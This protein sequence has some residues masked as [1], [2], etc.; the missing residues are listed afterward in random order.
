M[1]PGVDLAYED[2]LDLPTEPQPAVSME[3]IR[4]FAAAYLGDTPPD[5]EVV[6][7]LHADPRGASR[8]CS[9]RRRPAT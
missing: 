8:R 6:N 2:D 7:G 9:S 1:C 3:Q 4:S 5:D